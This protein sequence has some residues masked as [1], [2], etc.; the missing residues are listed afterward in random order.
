MGMGR[1]RPYRTKPVGWKSLKYR[2]RSTGLLAQD[3]RRIIPKEANLVC[4]RSRLL[5]LVDWVHEMR[6]MGNSF[7]ACEPRGR[8]W[9]RTNLEHVIEEVGRRTGSSTESLPRNKKL[10]ERG[11]RPSTAESA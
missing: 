11:F 10:Q 7:D 3:D 5:Q 4:A 9:N 8:E 2:V 6:T 1:G